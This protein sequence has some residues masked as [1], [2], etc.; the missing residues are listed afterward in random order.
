[1]LYPEFATCPQKI[2]AYSAPIF[3]SL[4]GFS[5]VYEGF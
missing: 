1:M 2:G 3:Q 4:C 5:R